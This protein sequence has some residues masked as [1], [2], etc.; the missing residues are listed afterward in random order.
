MSRDF[1]YFYQFGTRL[2]CSLN[3]M[4]YTRLTK[5]QFDERN[6]AY[7]NKEEVFLFVVG[8]DE[9]VDFVK[10]LGEDLLKQD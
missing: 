5:E 6:D 2:K 3:A 9:V 7:Y 8:E 4:K 10:E 1:F